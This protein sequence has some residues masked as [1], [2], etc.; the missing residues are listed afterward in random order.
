MAFCCEAQSTRVGQMAGIR[1]VPISP[2]GN[3]LVEAWG[4]ARTTYGF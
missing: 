1:D 3:V 4:W 2:M